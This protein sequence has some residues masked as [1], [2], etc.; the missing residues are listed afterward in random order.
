MT[1]KRKKMMAI[2]SCSVQEPMRKKG[3][4]CER[5]R[6][7]KEAHEN[8]DDMTVKTLAVLRV[9]PHFSSSLHPPAPRARFED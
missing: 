7:V 1:F 3:W 4:R 5:A 6:L 8:A 9:P 2:D